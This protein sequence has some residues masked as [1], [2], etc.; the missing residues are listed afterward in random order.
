MISR[1]PPNL[2]VSK[3]SDTAIVPKRGSAYAAGLDLFTPTSGVVDP[4]K[5]LLVKL[6]IA[7]ELPQGTFGHILPRSGLALKNGIHIGAGV[8][9]EDYRGNVG[10]LLFNLG[11]EPYVFN[12]GDRIAQL[13]VKPY[14]RVNVFEND[15]NVLT[16]SQRGSGGF[17]S[18]GR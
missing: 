2:V 3:L 14:M 15:T 6:D 13:V 1:Q 18:S 10:V 17:G 5:R 7:I 4:G 12:A 9:D 16:E 11:E 8:I